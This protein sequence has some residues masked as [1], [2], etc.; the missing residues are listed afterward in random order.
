MATRYLKY[1]MIHMGMEEDEFVLFLGNIAWNDKHGNKAQLIIYKHMLKYAKRAY[2]RPMA[3]PSVIMGTARAQLIELREEWTWAAAFIITSTP[4]VHWEQARIAGPCSTCCIQTCN[5]CD[6]CGGPLCYECDRAEDVGE[7]WHCC[8]L[9]I[10]S[11][12]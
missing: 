2:F 10:K 6:E 12:N 5:K 11:V 3:R 8:G 9:C 4:W 7:G 1:M